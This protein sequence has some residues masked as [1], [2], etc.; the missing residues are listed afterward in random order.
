[1]NTLDLV[2]AHEATEKGLEVSEF[3]IR[4]SSIMERIETMRYQIPL[5][6]SFS[7]NEI[8][9]YRIDPIETR[10]INFSEE[11]KENKKYNP[12]TDLLE[13]YFLSSSIEAKNSWRA[14]KKWNQ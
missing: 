3:L 8:D 5:L 6:K 4:F 12:F 7:E 10:V 14:N 13:D 2:K 11:F 1:M 9:Y